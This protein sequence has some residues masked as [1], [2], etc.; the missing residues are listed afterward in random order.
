MVA[1]HPPGTLYIDQ[2]TGHIYAAYDTNND[3]VAD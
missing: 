2:S 1:D 3:G